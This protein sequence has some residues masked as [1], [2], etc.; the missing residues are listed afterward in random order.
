MPTE[1]EWEYAARGG[2]N[3]AYWWG[4]AIGKGNANCGGSW[5]YDP[6]SARVSKR[7]RGSPDNN[8]DT[9]G[10]RLAQDI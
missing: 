10:V 6:F 5:Y 7:E 9:L 4:A 2:T 8:G 3:T 1:A